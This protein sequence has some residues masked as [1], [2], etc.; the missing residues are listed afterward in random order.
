M[1]LREKHL[2][3][4]GVKRVE[5]LHG[6]AQRKHLTFHDLRATGI[7][8]CAVRADE[9]LR[10]KQRAGHRTFGTTEGYI[11]EAENLAVGFGEP[12]PELPAD[13]TDPAGFGSF[14]FVSEFRYRQT[15]QT[16]RDLR[17]EGDSNP[18]YP[19]GHT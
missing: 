4:A 17:R 19:H 8:W 14:G 12:F 13:L 10:I 7:T 16:S 9:P 18:W 1:L 6:N 11:R 3:A 5:L 15:P 2:P